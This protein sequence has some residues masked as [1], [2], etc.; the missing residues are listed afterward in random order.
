MTTMTLLSPPTHTSPRPLPWRRMAWVTWRQHRIAIGGMALFLG[1]IAVGL[2][3]GGLQVHHAYAVALTCHP[4][5][6]LFCGNLVK[7]FNGIDDFLA[8]GVIFQAVPPLIGAFVGASVLARE[9]ESGTYRFA[10]TQGFGRWRWTLAKLTALGVVVAAS[11]GVFSFLFSWYFQ[12]YFA[13]RNPDLSLSTASPFLPGLFDLRALTFAAW[14]LAAFAIGALAGLLI[15]RVVPAIVATLIAYGGLGVLGAIVR[16]HY[17]AAIV[18]RKSNVPRSAMIVSQ[19]G[20]RNGRL[21]WT[22]SLP[23]QSL[24]RSNCPP[25]AA[26]GVSVPKPSV[27]DILRCLPG[28]GY[29]QWTSYQPVSRLSTFQWIESGWLVAVSALLVGITVWVVRRRAT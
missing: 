9:F 25:A 5:N 28:H 19:W 13:A 1:A 26:K 8:N 10:W 29:A 15:R 2:W 11:A 6:S 14:T 17:L 23:P 18:T 3:V 21:A 7:R 4:A 27:E 16:P 24:L 20:T 12:P 22:G